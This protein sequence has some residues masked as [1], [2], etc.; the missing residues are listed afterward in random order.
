[1]D[2]QAVRQVLEQIA[3]FLELRAENPFRVRA[4]V[5]AARTIAGYS[6]D[7]ADGLASGALA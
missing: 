2:K 4:Y 5:N 6:G 3:A 7:L 1:M